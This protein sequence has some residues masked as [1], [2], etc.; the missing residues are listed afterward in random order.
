MI[1]SCRLKGNISIS[2]GAGTRQTVSPDAVWVLVLRSKM[3]KVN[4][5]EKNYQIQIWMSNSVDA[6]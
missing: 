1:A 4:V 3:E 2:P 6:A 5:I